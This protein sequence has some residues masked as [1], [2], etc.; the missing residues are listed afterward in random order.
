[1]LTF[2]FA[3]QRVDTQVCA[4]HAH[5]HQSRP[6]IPYLLLRA[7]N[8]VWERDFA[9]IHINMQ[10]FIGLC[11]IFRS[12]DLLSHQCHTLCCRGGADRGAGRV[13][14]GLSWLSWPVEGVHPRGGG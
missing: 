1:M 11:S 3:A 13:E 5:R 6:Y 9:H 8:L 2:H 7:K 14:G 12:G 10:L 4:P